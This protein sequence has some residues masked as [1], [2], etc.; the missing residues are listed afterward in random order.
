MSEERAKSPT[1]CTAQR[2]PSPSIPGAIN[3]NYRRCI[4]CR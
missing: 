4:I 2:R 1:V 3:S